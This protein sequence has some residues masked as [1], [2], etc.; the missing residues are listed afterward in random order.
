MKPVRY[1]IYVDGFNVYHALKEEYKQYLWLNY[2]ALAAFALPKNSIIKRIVYFSAHAM[3][4][5]KAVDR[6]R[7]YIKALR[8][9]QIEIVL[10]K[11]KK[12]WPRCNKC[13]KKYLSHEEKLTD[14]NIALQV[15]HDAVLDVYDRA[16]IITA[17][18]DLIPAIDMVHTLS[19]GKDVGVMLPIG[20]NSYD[21]KGKADF[22]QKMTQNMLRKSL[23]PDIIHAGND[24]ITKPDTWPAP[25]DLPPVSL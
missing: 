9:A 3:W 2:R 24:V 7:E 4:K 14:V 1:A 10:G 15:V 25:P 21:L 6:H 12:K 22:H 18:S 11:F 8:S 13:H 20:R 19:P 16:L 5:P 17:D 23:F